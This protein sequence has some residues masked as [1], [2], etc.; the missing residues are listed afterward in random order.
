MI[1]GLATGLLVGIVLALSGVA[2]AGELFSDVSVGDTHEPG[3]TWA[4][5]NGLIAGFA[6][7]TFR[8]GDPVTRGQLATILER[9]RAARHSTVLLTPIC[10]ETTMLVTTV[11]I[12]GTGA[13]DVE[14]SVD[15]GDRILIP[16]GIPEEEGAVAF[17]PG[18]PG[19]ISLFIDSQAWA[20][21]PTAETCTPPS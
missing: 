13:A 20:H 9:Q 3:I 17:D 11:P 5:E 2:L 1:K 15:G 12:G 4:Y 10:G 18:T 16:G 19:M 14:Y 6:D 7:G 8:P 21:A